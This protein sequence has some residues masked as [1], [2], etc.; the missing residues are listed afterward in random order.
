VGGSWK[1]GRSEILKKNTH[2]ETKNPECEESA[3]VPEGQDWFL[4]K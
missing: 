2:R 3:A 4:S 1:E